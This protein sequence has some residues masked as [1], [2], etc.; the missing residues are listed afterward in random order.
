MTDVIK[1]FYENKSWKCNCVQKWFLWWLFYKFEKFNVD[2]NDKC[3]ELVKNVVKKRKIKS[4]CDIWCSR[5]TLLSKLEKIL[6]D[7]EYIQWI[8]IDEKILKEAKANVKNG[9]FYS[10]DINQ[11]FKLHQKC[12]LITC[13]A[14][15][16]H[17]FSPE[18]VVKNISEN[19]NRVER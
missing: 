2:R 16:E 12:D 4:V 5:G 11:S 8:D 13:L 9:D 19:I 17:V 14:V 18:D 10:C 3:I 7:L 6:P 15:I 1:D